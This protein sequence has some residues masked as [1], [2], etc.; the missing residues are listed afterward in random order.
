MASNSHTISLSP[1]ELNRIKDDQ[2]NDWV[3]KGLR[4]KSVAFIIAPPDSGKGYLC[5]SIA[6]ELATKINIIGVRHENTPKLKTLYWPME[7]RCENTADRILSHFKDMSETTRTD[8]ISNIQLY[9]QYSAIAY[10]MKQQNSTLAMSCEEAKNKLIESA[11]SFDVLIIDTIRESMGTADEV[12][13]DSFI[14]ATLKEIADKADVAIIAVHHPTKNV[15]RGVEA[16]SSVSGSGL[17]YTIANSRL[18]LYLDKQLKKNK[19]TATNLKHVKANFLN[20]KERIDTPV[21]WTDNNLMFINQNELRRLGVNSSA[22]LSQNKIVE[23][24]STDIQISN[25]IPKTFTISD[26]DLEQ[27]KRV[28][29]PQEVSFIDK[30]LLDKLKQHREKTNK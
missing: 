11:K 25:E 23:V 13:D 15:A 4:R 12:L 28:V 14:N 1:N 5:L 26:E 24:K 8:C 21:F 9:H 19:S 22:L 2:S 16:I 6:Y 7:D 17:S 20:S 10:S 27:S 18:H 29:M 3:L 30:E